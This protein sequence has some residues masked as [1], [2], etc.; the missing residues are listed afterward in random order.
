[1]KEA[2][3]ANPGRGAEPDRQNEILIV[4]DDPGD[5]RLIQRAFESVS[6]SV[7]L[8]FAETGEEAL[9]YLLGFRH[10]PGSGELRPRLVLLDLNVPNLDGRRIL[11]EIREDARLH[12]VPV[13]VFSG[14]N[15]EADVAQCYDLGANS[16][17]TKPDS[18]DGY[19]E[20]IRII[21]SYWLRQAALPPE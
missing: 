6:S 12:R 11:R 13:V 9:E 17:F 1:M 4:E 21:E 14:S 3:E 5:R 10:Y 15:S 19:R 18:P 2:E 16:F 20:T 8:R 7:E